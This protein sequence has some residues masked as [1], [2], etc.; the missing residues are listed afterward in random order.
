MC[1]AGITF[2]DANAIFLRRK[3]HA[4]PRMHSSTCERNSS[5]RGKLFLKKKKKVKRPAYHNANTFFLHTALL[6][7]KT[8]TKH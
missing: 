3:K 4:T 7:S 2:A 8:K 6:R 5:K 1:S